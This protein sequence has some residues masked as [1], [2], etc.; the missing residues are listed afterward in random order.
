MA[1]EDADALRE[2]LLSP[3][4]SQIEYAYYDAEDD[5]WQ[6]EEEFLEAEEGDG[7]QMPQYFILTFESLS[8]EE[9]SDPHSPESPFE[10]S[11]T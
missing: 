9:Q 3:L 1:E 6:R 8:G 5:E 7:Q 2:T 4:V 10:F 11:N